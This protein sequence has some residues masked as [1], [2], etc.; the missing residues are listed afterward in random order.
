MFSLVGLLQHAAK[1]IRCGRSF[2][3]RMYATVAKVHE[4]DYFTWL[5]NDFRADL[6]W[7]YTFLAEWNG[8]SFL[9]HSSLLKYHEFCSQTDASG[10]WSYAAFFKGNWIQLP[11]NNSWMPVGI[12]AKKLAPILLSIA[13]GAQDLD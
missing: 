12:I 13:S 2:V 6:N 4:L 1:L 11:W 9:C 10:S 5:N 8:V 7:W 3:S